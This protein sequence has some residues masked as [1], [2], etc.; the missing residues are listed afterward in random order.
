MFGFFLKRPLWTAGVGWFAQLACWKSSLW[1][2]FKQ[3]W[4]CSSPIPRE[5]SCPFQEIFIL[6]LPMYRTL[7]WCFMC[8]R[9]LP[10]WAWGGKKLVWTHLLWLWR[11]R[12]R[13]CTP[14]FGRPQ[15]HLG[16]SSHRHILFPRTLC[17]RFPHGLSCL[18]PQFV[19][20]DSSCLTVQRRRK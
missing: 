13:G 7:L 11:H 18:L 17:A 4:T 9:N 20:K 2:Q 15:W 10:C 12:L 6:L 5:M 16:C 8:V 1:A 3:Q 14:A 19:Q